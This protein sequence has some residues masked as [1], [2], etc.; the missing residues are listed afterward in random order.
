MEEYSIQT[1]TGDH[2]YIYNG[3]NQLALDAGK[4]LIEREAYKL[5]HVVEKIDYAQAGIGKNRFLSFS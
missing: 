1:F 5:E 4:T 3:Y 2:G